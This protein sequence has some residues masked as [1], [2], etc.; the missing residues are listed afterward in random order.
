MDTKRLVSDQDIEFYLNKLGF[1]GYD[2]GKGRLMLMELIVKAAAGYYNSSTEEGF[3][4]SF[5]VIRKDRTPNRRGAKF[6]ASMVC[7]SS[8]DRPVSYELMKKHRR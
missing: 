5:G 7:A 8:N 4:N 2:T 3:L 6:I 1:N